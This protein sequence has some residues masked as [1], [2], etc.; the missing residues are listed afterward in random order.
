MFFQ[1]VAHRV[2]HRGRVG[3][4]GAATAALD[5]WAE[6]IRMA[7]KCNRL[8]GAGRR[9]PPAS[10]PQP[11][12]SSAALCYTW[13]EVA[14]NGRC[15]GMHPSKLTMAM[16]GL[17]GGPRGRPLLDGAAGECCAE[18]RGFGRRVVRSRVASAGRLGS[19]TEMPRSK[20][21]KRRHDPPSPEAREQAAQS[22]SHP[23]VRHL[24]RSGRVGE[25]RR[26]A[27][28]A[29]PGRRD[30]VSQSCYRRTGVAGAGRKPCQSR[31]RPPRVGPF[32]PLRRP[33]SHLWPSQP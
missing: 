13:R 4:V 3:S 31:R 33:L 18:V 20:S 9:P 5:A 22:A 32:H 2:N 8:S 6:Y 25:R 11:W 7:V 15:G 16:R 30:C 29:V 14:G 12:A 23:P 19:R 10:A 21:K 28:V 24:G 27:V 26:V 17:L 1:R